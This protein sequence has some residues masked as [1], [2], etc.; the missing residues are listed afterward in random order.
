MWQQPLEHRLQYRV[1]KALLTGVSFY[2]SYSAE[3]PG[4]K[5]AQGGSEEKTHNGLDQ[6]RQ[7]R[8]RTARA[9]AVVGNGRAC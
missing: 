3:R 7:G 8:Y 5:Y 2:L 9:S 6:R 1:S 4:S